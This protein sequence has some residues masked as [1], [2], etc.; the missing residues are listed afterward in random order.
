MNKIEKYDLLRETILDDLFDKEP[1]AA[2]LLIV[3]EDEYGLTD[4]HNKI[5]KEFNAI[6]DNLI[7]K[8]IKQMIEEDS[9]SFVVKEVKRS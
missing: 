1:L 6:V 8:R 2:S 7:D 9:K 5:A 4:L 3:L